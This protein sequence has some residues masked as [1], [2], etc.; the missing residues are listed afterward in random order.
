MKPKKKLFIALAFVLFLAAFPLFAN[1]QPDVGI[2][3]VLLAGAGIVA[4]PKSFRRLVCDTA[5]L[6]FMGREG[7]GVEVFRHQK[8]GQLTRLIHDP[9]QAEEFYRRH[10]NP[11]LKGVVETIDSP[12]YGFARLT[13]ATLNA[14]YLTVQIGGSNT[15][16]T[17]TEVHTN[18]A[19]P[20]KLGSVEKMNVDSLAVYVKTVVAADLAIVLDAS[21]FT[22]YASRKTYWQSPTHGLP[23]GFGP[24]GFTTSTATNIL[25]SG[26]PTETSRR[27]LTKIIE[28]EVGESIFGQIDFAGTAAGVSANTDTWFHLFGQR[29]RAI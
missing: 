27:R 18:M 20:G 21:F 3:P 26:L 7:P 24:Y 8:S 5:G 16:V 2:V 15:G 28:L 14:K 9:D 25:S 4:T 29:D 1:P 13:S 22:F 10:R 19:E 11:S 17:L 12:L 23:S 6:D